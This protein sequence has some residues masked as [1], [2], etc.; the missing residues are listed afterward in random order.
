[1]TSKSLCK[2]LI[3]RLHNKTFQQNHIRHGEN[4][5]DIFS[6]I[7]KK[8]ASY[9]SV[10]L[11]QKSLKNIL[12]KRCKKIQVRELSLIEA[13]AKQKA[14]ETFNG[15]AWVYRKIKRR[16]PKLNVVEQQVEIDYYIRCLVESL[17]PEILESYAR[18]YAIIN[19][20]NDL[21]KQFI[22]NHYNDLMKYLCSL[23]KPNYEQRFVLPSG[24]PYPLSNEIGS[25]L[26]S[27][28]YFMQD[29]DIDKNRIY[30]AIGNYLGSAIRE[31][32]GFY[33]HL[34]AEIQNKIKSI[35][36]FI[37]QADG[38]NK[39][40]VLRKSDN[41]ILSNVGDLTG[42]YNINRKLSKNILKNIEI[43]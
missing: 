16:F 32:H 23:F 38:Q 11:I 28:Y 2:E 30:Y 15:F 17:Y 33:G 3:N 34:F 19:G 12:V 22:T 13:A 29:L 36:T 27:Q 21:N 5:K 10:I 39:F 1:M 14:F 8:N 26:V 31:T 6:N 4:H 43:Y 40:K 37:A 35:P 41:L 20:G 42:N 9:F 7:N 18:G 24:I 25:A